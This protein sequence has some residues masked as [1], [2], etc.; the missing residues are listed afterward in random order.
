MNKNIIL[1]SILSLFLI[2]FIVENSVLLS[3]KPNVIRKLKKETR[4]AQER[5]NAASIVSN[6]DELTSVYKIFEVNL[7]KDKK[8]LN[9]KTNSDFLEK[10]TDLF[11]E[12][13]IVGLNLKPDKKIKRGKYNYNSYKI[14][15]LATFEQFSKLVNQLEIDNQLIQIDNFTIENRI[16]KLSG[17]MKNNLSIHNIEFGLS[18]ITF[19]K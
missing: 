9:D 8:H 10:L 19:L 14:K 4:E 15:I 13:N 3:K 5:Y 2:T 17:K 12:L 18:T 16:K 11:Q 6:S 7:V 1:G